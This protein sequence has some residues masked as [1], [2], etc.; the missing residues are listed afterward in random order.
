MSR[1]LLKTALGLLELLVGLSACFGG[2]QL[3]RD[4]SGGLLQLPA[5]RY[6]LGTP[7]RDFFVPGVV[8]LLALGLF[9]L[10]VGLAAVLRQGWVRYGHLAVGA[11]VTGWM[12]V[13]LYL[14]SYVFVLQGVVL[15]AGL[16]ILLLATANFFLDGRPPRTALAA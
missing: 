6:L 13:Q 9:P 11:V 2:I 10:A 8:L 14:L 4:P 15:A 12:L 1:I 7:F 5:Q 16:I 3:V